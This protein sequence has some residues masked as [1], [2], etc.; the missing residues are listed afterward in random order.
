MKLTH[1]RQKWEDDEKITVDTEEEA[2]VATKIIEE[3][4]GFVFTSFC[5]Y[6]WFGTDRGPW[7]L[8]MQ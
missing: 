1:F 2:I 4:S 8:A 5:I 7:N 3:V 6:R